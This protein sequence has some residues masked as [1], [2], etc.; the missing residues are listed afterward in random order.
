M[1]SAKLAVKVQE[2]YVF[3]MLSTMASKQIS[4]KSWVNISCYYYCY[5]HYFIFVPIL[6]ISFFRKIF[7]L[8]KS[9][10]FSLAIPAKNHFCLALAA[11]FWEFFFP[12]QNDR[13][14]CSQQVCAVFTLPACFDLLRSKVSH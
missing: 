7:F 12:L 2:N 14:L 10:I 5:C 8:K 4:Y 11:I 13:V 3:K 9:L 6:R 1:L